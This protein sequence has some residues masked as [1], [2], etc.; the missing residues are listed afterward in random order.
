[1]WRKTS[2]KSCTNFRESPRVDLLGIQ[3]ERVWLEIDTGKL[4]SVGVQLECADQGSS[5]PEHRVCLPATSMRMARAYLLETSG[6]FPNVRAIETMLTRVGTTDS[7][8]RLP[9][10]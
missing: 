1:M 6:D 3:D 9:T 8:V 5:G 4:G 10:S 2:A 7:L